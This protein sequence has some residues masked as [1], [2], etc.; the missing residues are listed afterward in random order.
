[1]KKLISVKFFY[2]Q[3]VT[4]DISLGAHDY[5]TVLFIMDAISFMIIVLGAQSFGVGL[6]TTLLHACM[7]IYSLY[8]VWA[9]LYKLVLYETLRVFLEGTKL[10]LLILLKMFF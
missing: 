9:F 1:M 5:Y 7:F 8:I 10:A 6:H 4:P 3:I 2:R